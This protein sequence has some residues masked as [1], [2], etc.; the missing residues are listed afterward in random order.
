MKVIE[1][2]DHNVVKIAAKRWVDS[3]PIESWDAETGTL[4][5]GKR[6]RRY[7]NRLTRWVHNITSLI[8]RRFMR[9]EEA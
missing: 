2:W 6:N 8:Q 9:G 7:R 4:T 3:Y 5:L 1:R